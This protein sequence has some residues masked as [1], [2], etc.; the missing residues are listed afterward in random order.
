MIRI[1]PGTTVEVDIDQKDAAQSLLQPMFLIGGLVLSQVSHLTGLEPHTIQ[2]WV[3][4]GFLSP[5]V[6]KRYSCRQLCRILLINM[7][8]DCLQLEKIC[9]L[10]SYLN[11]HLDDES[12]DLI[13]DSQLY[14]Y[15]T[16]LTAAIEHD[17]CLNQAQLAETCR[18]VM[19]GY[20]EPWPG[21]RD[22]ILRV[23]EIVGFAWAAGRLKQEAELLIGGLD[24]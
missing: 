12:D 16:E 24:A 14:F 23:L 3:K 2:N 4:R 5:P 18:R 15:V 8:R 11:G 19:A 17:R 9:G 7:L 20:E 22:R 1:L 10:L 13:D 21:A 6:K